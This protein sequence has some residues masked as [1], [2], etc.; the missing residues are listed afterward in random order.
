MA[1]GSFRL[2]ILTTDALLYLLVACVIAFLWAGSRREYYVMAWRQI[3]S[4]QIPMI[5]LGVLLI[6]VAVALL[7][8]VHYQ[9]RALTPEAQQQTDNAGQAV[10]DTE[11]LSLLDRL[12]AGLRQRTEKTF[13]APFATR[14]FTKELVERD[15][16]KV[17]DFPDLTYGGQHLT[18]VADR[19]A[20]ILKTGL[21]GLFSGM[22]WS[23]VIFSVYFVVTGIRS[24]GVGDGYERSPHVLRLVF[25]LVALV[26]AAA[27]LAALSAK[28][29]VFGTDQVGKDVL[30]RSLKGCRVGLVVGTLTTLIATPVAIALGIAA[31]YF[32]GWIDDLI[33]YVYTTLSSIPN[34]LLITAVMLIVTSRTSDA[35]TAI[36]A[37]QRLLW[38]CVVLGIGSWTGLCR[39]L[40]GETLKVREQE[41]IQASEAFGVSRIKI[42]FRHILPNVLHI[43]LITMILRF[44]GLVLAEAVLAYV[45]IGVDPSMESW[46][47]MINAARLEVARDPIVWWNLMAAFVFMIGLVLPA[48]IFGDAVRDAL[49]PRL[50]TE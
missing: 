40:R 33:Q 30:Y 27:I 44:S 19:P 28:Y 2:L 47:N 12:C 11:I 3:R 16:V 42:M 48:N 24:R 22:G 36:A 23:L 21:W 31:G 49:D 34:I 38:L 37:D 46:G 14:Q 45:G 7:D 39:L 20:D 15:G 50:R 10:Y 43:V 5:C 9:S 13:S 41:Y 1:F 18:S 6:Y 26:I 4:R 17:R 8:S 35:Q 32:G 29:H 25:F